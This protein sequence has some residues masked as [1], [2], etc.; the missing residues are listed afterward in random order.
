VE[1]VRSLLAN[2]WRPCQA[3]SPGSYIDEPFN[4]QRAKIDYS[5]LFAL[6]A[7]DVSY[8]IVWSYQNFLR[9]CG[10][11]NHLVHFHRVQVQHRN[12]VR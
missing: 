4:L 10:C 5:Y 12:G 9:R 1:G 3:V 8:L 6:I 11:V 7:R 2:C